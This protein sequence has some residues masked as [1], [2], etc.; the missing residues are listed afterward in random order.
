MTGTTKP[1]VDVRVAIVIV[2]FNTHD[3][4]CACLRSLHDPPPESS[5]QIVVVDNGSIDK[6]IDTVRATW[7]AVRVVEMG[8]NAGFAAAT[9][10]GVDASGSD[11]VLL[12]NSD[13]R[14]AS[15]SVD[16]LIAALETDPTAAAAG[17]RLVDPSGRPELSFGRMMSPWNEAR[18]KLLGLGVAYRLRPFT[19]W[20][21][22]RSASA[23]Y[24]DWVSGACLLVRRSWGDTV[25]WLDERFFLYGEDV[26]FC[27]ALRAAGRR[28]LF[29]PT[30]E[31]VHAGGQSGSTDPATTRILYRRSHLAFYAKHHPQWVSVLRWYFRLRGQLPPDNA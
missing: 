16:R 28:I 13:T 30:A 19:R 15:G 7:P 3:A 20:L 2:S 8:R 22:R 27:A 23:H 24:P 18:Q 4:L 31:V 26:D 25:G 14:V 5:H 10:A 21:E 1:A 29:A 11:L 6:S 9:N 12:L 17:P